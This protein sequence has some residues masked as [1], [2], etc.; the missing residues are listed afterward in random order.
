MRRNYIG[1]AVG[2]V[3]EERRIEERRSR[4]V[5]NNEGRESSKCQE[6]EERGSR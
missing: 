4:L 5:R 3:G 2:R 1:G 6:N